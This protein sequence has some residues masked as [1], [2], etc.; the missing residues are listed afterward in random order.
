[1]DALKDIIYLAYEHYVITAVFLAIL[2][3]FTPFKGIIT[4]CK[5]CKIAKGEQND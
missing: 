3:C 2:S 1:M 4:V 5:D